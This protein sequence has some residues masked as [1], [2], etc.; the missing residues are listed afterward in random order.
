MALVQNPTYTCPDSGVVFRLR[1]IP[2]LNFDDFNNAYDEQY[3][4]PKPPLIA[5]RV[6]D[7]VITQPDSKD[8]YYLAEFARWNGKKE[9]AARHFMFYMGIENDPPATYQPDR[10]LFAGDLPNGKRKALW[11]SDQLK[12]TND[13]KGLIEAIQSL[14]TITDE[15]I[16]AEKNFTALEPEVLTSS[17]GKSNNVQKVSDLTFP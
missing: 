9:A 16:E 1:P 13:I 5:V 10:G 11:V 4:P 7:K 12:T 2:P 3:P 8:E 17:V 14:L 6:A 15:A